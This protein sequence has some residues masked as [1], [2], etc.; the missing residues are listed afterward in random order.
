[1]ASIF[2]LKCLDEHIT[3]NNFDFQ[4]EPN[5]NREKAFENAANQENIA[6]NILLISQSINL[7]AT[8]VFIASIL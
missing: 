7:I 8:L 1:M 2:G 4:N 5:K 6:V 3:A